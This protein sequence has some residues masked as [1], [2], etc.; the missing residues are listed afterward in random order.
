MKTRVASLILVLL[1]AIGMPMRSGLAQFMAGQFPV[2][3]QLMDRRTN[4]PAPG[5]MVSLI[6][7][8]FGRSVPS[9]SNTYGGFGWTT[10]PASPQPYMIEVYWGTNL[11]YRQPLLVNGPLTLGPIFL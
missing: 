6:H 5:L 2:Q 1:V 3:G 11:I 8:Q 7:P 10:I 9:Y 4:M